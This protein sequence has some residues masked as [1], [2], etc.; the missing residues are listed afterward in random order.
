MTTAPCLVS[1]P[2]SAL[3]GRNFSAPFQS[4]WRGRGRRCSTVQIHAIRDPPP[5]PPGPP[6]QPPVFNRMEDMIQNRLGSDGPQAGSRWREVAG[7]WVLNP[8]GNE[9]SVVVHFVGG[10][11]VGAAPQLAYRPFLEALA[12]RGAVVIATP[13]HTGFDHTRVADEVHFMYQR[14][15]K[16]LG[17]RAQ[18]LPTYGVGHSL[19]SLLQLLLASRYVVQPAGNILMSF[20]NKPVTDAI[21]LFSS[22]IAPGSQ[23]IGPLLSQLAA[24][25]LR[26]SL[27]GF[28]ASLKSQ[29]PDV[30][31]QLTP[32]IEQLLPIYTDIAKGTREF[33]PSPAECKDMIREGYGVERN[34]LIRFASDPI[35]DTPQ[36]AAT[37]E[38]SSIADLLDL[39]QVT[40]PGTHVRP[41]QQ[42]FGRLTSDVGKYAQAARTQSEALIDQ[43]AQMA[44][45]AGVPA[46]ATDG[47]SGFARAA[48]GFAGAFG[49]AMLS[50]TTELDISSLADECGV[51]MGIV[52][53]PPATALGVSPDAGRAGFTPRT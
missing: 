46:E 8:P 2:G 44:R 1:S 24:S 37:L 47:L 52:V 11:F 14:A 49:E 39:Q 34:L 28:L 38:M 31:R 4:A 25:P 10:A 13:F 45:G 29:S 50:S 32:V 20:N 17:P 36:L 23:F 18:R 53:P 35:D 7:A 5:P 33:V 16:A 40:L 19:G 43:L 6:A 21:P 26:S 48:T 42:E 51:F 27:E 3:R 9:P 12:A 30:V 22:Y 41:L 15:L